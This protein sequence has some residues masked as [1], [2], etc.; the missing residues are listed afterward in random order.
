M[1]LS[2]PLRLYIKKGAPGLQIY[3]SNTKLKHSFQKYLKN[4][5][6]QIRNE[7]RNKKEDIHLK[8]SYI[9]SVKPISKY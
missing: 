9:H 4:K 8:G 7:N 1:L 2:I 3:S 5:Q 6:R